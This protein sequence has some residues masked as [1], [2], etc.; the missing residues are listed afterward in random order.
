MCETSVNSVIIC[1]S[2]PSCLSNNIQEVADT[3][4][5]Y[6]TLMELIV[7]LASHGLIHCDY[8]EFNILINERGK[9]TLIDFPQMVSTSHMNAQRCSQILI[10]VMCKKMLY[11]TIGVS[12]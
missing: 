11:L 7:R 3:P 2:L 5:L 10:A 1:H 9:P 8:N 4:A 12:S 6:S